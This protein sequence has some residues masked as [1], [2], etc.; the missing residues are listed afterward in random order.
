M[1]FGKKNCPRSRSTEDASVDS[2]IVDFLCDLERRVTTLISFGT[3]RRT[4]VL[5]APLQI[6]QLRSFIFLCSDRI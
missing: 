5:L 6:F 3:L 2:S 4:M 1:D